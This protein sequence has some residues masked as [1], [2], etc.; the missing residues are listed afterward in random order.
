MVVWRRESHIV[1]RKL[2][3][4]YGPVVR[5]GPNMV[6]LDFPSYT[7]TVYNIKGNW[8]KVRGRR[9]TDRQQ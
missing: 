7:K 9:E 3:D 6:I 4:K 2:H 1:G 8:S 5:V